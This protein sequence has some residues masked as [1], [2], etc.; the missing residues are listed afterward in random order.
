[1]TLQPN[2]AHLYIYVVV[3][4]PLLLVGQATL[5]AQAT[6]DVTEITPNLLVFSTTAGNVVASVGKDG[7]FL[8]GTPTTASTPRSAAYLRHERSLLFGIWLSHRRTPVIPKATLA[9][10]IAGLS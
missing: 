5:S 1:M 2:R 10:N 3:L 6:V 9:G 8:V 7:A 4:L